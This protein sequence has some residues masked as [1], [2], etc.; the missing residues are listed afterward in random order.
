LLKDFGT[1]GYFVRDRLFK[2]LSIYLNPE[3]KFWMNFEFDLD[4]FKKQFSPYGQRGKLFKILDFLKEQGEL[5]YKIKKKKIEICNRVFEK[6][7]ESY[8]K[9]SRAAAEK[10]D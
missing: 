1:T 2:L 7:A 9:R 4:F 3:K 10:K 8:V 6:R 5:T